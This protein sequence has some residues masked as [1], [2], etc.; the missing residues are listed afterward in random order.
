MKDVYRCRKCGRYTED[1]VH[2]NV[3]ADLV[4]DRKRRVMLSKTLSAILRH[5]ALQ[6]EL[7]VSREG[8]IDIGELVA[9]LRSR[10]PHSHLYSWVN[11]EVIEAIA[12]LD[13]KGRFE[14]RGN[15]I[16]ARY[17]HT[18][19]VDIE[20]KEVSYR[21]KL[22]HGTAF[23]NLSSIMEK[24]LKPMKRNFVHLTTSIEDA[25]EV[26]RRK[27][28]NVVVLEIDPECLYKMGLKVYEASKKVY[29]TSYVPSHCIKVRLRLKPSL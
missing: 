21:G 27:S 14:I 11:G 19:K 22:Y 7:K 28:E 5:L 29:L 17:G 1:S 18:Y 2:C 12:L 9:F 24:G 8:W 13:P 6:L 26:G 23:E 25:I 15:R 20:F 3:K 4:V 10:W 16:R